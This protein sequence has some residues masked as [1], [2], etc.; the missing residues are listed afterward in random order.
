MLLN[1][2]LYRIAVVMMSLHNNRNQEEDIWDPSHS[3]TKGL[4]A[5]YFLFFHL[6]LASSLQFRLVVVKSTG[7]LLNSQV[8]FYLQW[9]FQ[10]KIRGVT[11]CSMI[12]V[13][14]YSWEALLVNNHSHPSPITIYE[15][16]SIFLP[17][18]KTYKL[19]QRPTQP[20]RS[21]LKIVT[22]FLKGSHQLFIMI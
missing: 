3:R 17:S 19:Q 13:S 12:L 8:K 4:Y 10:T 21:E 9:Q 16:Q 15:K 1:I 5:V 2:S 7:D 11:M 22:F 6:N 20:D 18:Y 14:F